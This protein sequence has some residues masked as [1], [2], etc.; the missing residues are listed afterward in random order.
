[1]VKNGKVFDEGSKKWV[2]QHSEYYRGVHDP[3][4][5]MGNLRTGYDGTGPAGVDA[6]IAH[7]YETIASRNLGPEDELFLFGYSRG[8][9]TVRCLAN[10][11]HYLRVPKAHNDTTQ[12]KRIYSTGLSL[13]ESIRTSPKSCPGK[14]NEYF[15]NCKQAHEMPVLKYVGVFDTV[16]AFDDKGLHDIG[17]VSSVLH[18][19]QALALHECRKAFEP[20]PFVLPSPSQ[21]C[22]MQQA[23]FVGAHADMGGAN[24]RDG[25][26]L[27]PLQWIVYE[28][29]LVGLTLGGFV[30]QHFETVAG[31]GL[32]LSD[33][34]KIIFPESPDQPRTR[35]R[36]DGSY[37]M[38]LSNKIRVHIWDLRAA[39][40]NCD[41][42]LS[43]NRDDSW[44]FG[45]VSCVAPER[46]RPIFE[47]ETR[48]LI[49]W[50]AKKPTGTF[51]HPSAY[52]FYD[53]WNDFTFRSR[54]WSICESFLKFRD[55]V[56][57]ADDT[58][59]IFWSRANYD[60]RPEK[61]RILICGESGIGKSTLI[62]KT[63][64]F[65]EGAQTA[66][67]VSHDGAGIHDIE[68]GYSAP[69]FG[70]A[71]H[72]S[73]GFQAGNQEDVN[74]FKNFIKRR[75]QEHDLAQRLH[76]IWY[77]VSCDRINRNRIYGSAEDMFMKALG[78][79]NRVPVLLIF[80]R[81]DELES[82][83]RGKIVKANASADQAVIESLV[84]RKVE[85]QLA[86]VKTTYQKKWNRN[87]YEGPVFI[88]EDDT[89][90]I[91]AVMNRTLKN[92]GQSSVLRDLCSS[93]QIADVDPK[94]ETALL[95]AFI[96]Y[97]HGVGW[98]SLPIPGTA[99]ISMPIAVE[100]ACKA[101][102]LAFKVSGFQIKIMLEV[103]STV[104]I[105]NYESNTAQLGTQ[106]INVGA[107]IADLMGTAG[108]GVV[109]GVSAQV[110]NILAVPQVGRVLIMVIADV[111]IIMDRA[112]WICK[113]SDREQK[114]ITAEDISEAC[115]IYGRSQSRKDVHE[116]TKAL[117]GIF[118]FW[119]SW[120]TRTLERQ[121]KEIV[122]RHRYG[123]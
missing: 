21:V 110:C 54:D 77:C 67:Q 1:M 76:T 23:W 112:F 96:C 100:R 43:I 4:S 117:I 50:T 75:K 49:G 3:T 16:K 19:R 35:Q 27:Y 99:L 61:F 13:Y 113:N 36:A 5:W 92:L 101:I 58:D 114:R 45:I 24:S 62:N 91:K 118:S 71:I 89:D 30:R 9:Y 87:C 38:V 59:A 31:P 102:M 121:V 34:E 64:G 10:I 14:I 47:T 53:W 25:L 88:E 78:P 85:E 28:A 42:K 69:G 48:D 97:G 94:I 29:K 106:A 123:K 104:F 55:H 57:T 41:Y 116:E 40:Q 37:V 15:K 44:L 115:T 8:A 68:H 109:A 86:R 12:I 74:D 90:S 79:G 95:N 65:P 46:D 39:F 20:E 111:T 32:A 60:K 2:F 7:L 63:F 18:Y 17:L 73:C 84:K 107:F 33:P 26:S 82:I 51:I 105:G 72:D 122:D 108:F 120:R 56:M 80:T 103:L 11:L 93:A 6:M 66:A 52:F 81:K 83:E 98:S 22:D 70:V 119:T